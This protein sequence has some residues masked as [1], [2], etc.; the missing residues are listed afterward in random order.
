M[1]EEA[2]VLDLDMVE[3]IKAGGSDGDG[4]LIYCCLLWLLLLL[5]LIVL[6]YFWWW[7]WWWWIGHFGET[8]GWTARTPWVDREALELIEEVWKG[9]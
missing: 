6:G 1:K 4:V 2:V 8:V 7:W 3:G 5:F 9:M